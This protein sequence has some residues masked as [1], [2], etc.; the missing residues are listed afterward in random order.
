MT[1]QARWAARIVGGLVAGG[2]RHVVVSPGSRSTPFL[3]AVLARDELIVHDIV[4]ERSAAFFALGIARVTDAPPLLLCTSGSAAG[5]YLPAVMEANAAQLPL[6]VLTADRPPELHDLGA[7]QTTDQQHLFGVHARAFF[8]LGAASE[9]EEVLRGTEA[10]AFLAA[11]RTRHPWPGPVHLNARARKPLEGRAPC[12]PTSTRAFFPSV[13]PDPDGLAWVASRLGRA[14]RPAIAMGPAPARV[15]ALR[16]AVRKLASALGAPVLADATSQMRFTGEELA[17]PRGALSL[18]TAAGRQRLDADLVLEVGAPPIDAGYA[19]WAEARPR[20]VLTEGA[21]VDPSASAEAFVV[22]ELEASL[23]ALASIEARSPW[24]Q[25]LPSLPTPRA[26]GPGAVAGAVVRA[27]AEGA[28]L[29]VGNSLAARAIDL[30]VSDDRDLVVLHQRGLSGIDGLVAGAAGAAHASGRPAT[31]LLGDVSLLHDLGSL[32]TVGEP[33]P[34]FRIVVVNDDGGRIFEQLPIHAHASD[35]HFERHFAM[36]HGR[37]F[38]EAA[39]L[40]GLDYER[41]ESI[42]ELEG[43]LEGSG[44]KL[45]EVRVEP[46]AARRELAQALAAEEKR[47]C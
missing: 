22:G 20:V 13:E 33:G 4:D 44:V 30:H 16:P 17:L 3:L 39:R 26:L 6:L 46:S 25:R 8:E 10:R 21:L 37:T 29:V 11:A 19:A 31:V 24:W 23:E 34:P 7:N 41:A 28:L 14:R 35:P 15:R 45:V 43:A 32:A 5:H 1:S 47:W 9:R 27:A 38:R 12:H 2:V 18:R 40:F 42:D 36:A